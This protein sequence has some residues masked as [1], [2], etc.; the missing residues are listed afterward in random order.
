MTRAIL[1]LTAVFLL[2]GCNFLDSDHNANRPLRM[3][4]P[5]S[6]ID[7]LFAQTKPV[8]F[9]RFLI[10]VPVTADVA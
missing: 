7:T 10:N 9:G 4:Q 8:C 2:A 5:N 3:N 6:K 1:T